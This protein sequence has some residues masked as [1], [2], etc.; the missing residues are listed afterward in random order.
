[1]SLAF[2]HPSVLE[3]YFE[4]HE[5]RRL[6]PAT[7]AT[8]ARTLD[9]PSARIGTDRCQELARSPMNSTSALDERRSSTVTQAPAP[10]SI[11][12]VS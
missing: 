8:M 12:A 7:S 3:E 6:T 10:S 9:P 2:A 5:L 11:R 1:M 4:S